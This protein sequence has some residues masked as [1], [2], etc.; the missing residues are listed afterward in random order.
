MQRATLLLIILIVLGS[1]LCSG[2][3][4]RPAPVVPPAPVALQA[5]PCPAPD[6]PLLPPVNG[7][8]PFD[9]PENVSVLM[10]RDDIYRTYAA[11]LEAAVKCYKVQTETH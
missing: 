11:G 9:S 2:C 6:R 4:A 3:S 8:L 10:E 1:C 7:A 5:V